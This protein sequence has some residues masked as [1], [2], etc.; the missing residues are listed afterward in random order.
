MYWCIIYIIYILLYSFNVNYCVHT[1]H[2]GVSIFISIGP[3]VR[4]YAERILEF[5]LKLRK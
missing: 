4:T 5:S 1:P 2:S 3:R